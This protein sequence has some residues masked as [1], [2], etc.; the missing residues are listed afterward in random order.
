MMVLAA[1]YGPPPG[2]KI[3][4]ADTGTDADADGFF[5]GED[6]NDDDAAI[7]PGAAEICDDGIDNDCDELIDDA[8]DECTE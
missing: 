3:D 7:N 6:C 5:V 1:C 2:D 8:D 4:S